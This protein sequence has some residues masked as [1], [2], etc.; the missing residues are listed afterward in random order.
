MRRIA[1]IIIILCLIY[2]IGGWVAVKFSF[3][4]KNDY[5][6]FAGIVGGLASVVGLLSFTRPAIT[7]DDLQ[8]IE[9][10]S[11]KSVTKTSE[12]LAD[13]KEKRSKTAVEI[14]TLE[15]QKK[16]MELLV[17][18]ASLSL[19]LSEQCSYYEKQIS[20]K[21][22]KDETLKS[23][24]SNYSDARE[25]LSVLNQEL[26]EHPNADLLLEVIEA[27]KE[28]KRSTSYS[29]L[30]AAISDL[31]PISKVI[32]LTSREIGLAFSN[33]FKIALK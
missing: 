20:E 8:K 21:I 22:I 29:K 12:E 23:Q 5:F 31:S 19:F 18:K 24:L 15:T 14:D 4:D 7:T 32:I 10:E 2:F 1:A 28:D 6:A 3:L 30:E 13:L 26:N 33:I 17:K 27:S 16:E 25:K 9:L 11:L